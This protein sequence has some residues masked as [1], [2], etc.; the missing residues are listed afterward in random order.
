MRRASRSDREAAPGTPAPASISRRRPGKS[1]ALLSRKATAS[2][3]SA[4]S[5]SGYMAARRPSMASS[6]GERNT[7]A[8]EDKQEPEIACTQEDQG[9]AAGKLDRQ[10]RSKLHNV[11]VAQPRIVSL[12]KT[13][14]GVATQC[15]I[16]TAEENIMSRPPEAEGPGWPSDY[17]A[18]SLSRFCRISEA[19]AFVKTSGKDG[20]G[21]VRGLSFLFPTSVSSCHV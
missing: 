15:G 16:I 21:A 6:R 8:P 12:R 5:G 9:K 1:S 17:S 3:G 2:A 10:A 18:F 7:F 4:S 19:C 20:S 13:Q 11:H 14:L